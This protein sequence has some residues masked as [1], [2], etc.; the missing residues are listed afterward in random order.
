MRHSLAEKVVVYL[1]ALDNVLFVT[2]FLNNS[3]I[4]HSHTHL[5]YCAGMCGD[6]TTT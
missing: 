2:M 4:P 5:P 1:Y 6:N 3:H